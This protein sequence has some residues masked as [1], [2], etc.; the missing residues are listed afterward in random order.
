MRNR[1]GNLNGVV[2]ATV[3]N[4]KVSCGW[5]K[6]NTAAGDVFDKE[7]ALKIAEGRAIKTMWNNQLPGSYIKEMATIQERGVRYFKVPA[8]GSIVP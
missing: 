5:S 1:K 7:L 8:D 3:V 4:G 2:L 6:C